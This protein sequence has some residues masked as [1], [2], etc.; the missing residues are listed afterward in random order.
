MPKHPFGPP[1]GRIETLTVEGKAL[2]G[3]LLGD[4]SR[5]QVSVYLPACYDQADRDYPLLVD[6]AGFTGSGPKHVAWRS[7]DESVPQRVDRLVAEDRM[8]PVIV[9]F[10]DCFTSLG[11]NQYVNS[12]AMGAWEDFLLDEMLPALESAL[13]VRRGPNHRAV[14]GKSSGGYGSL[15]QGLRHGERWAAIACHSGDMGFDFVYRRDLPVALTELA[16]FDGDAG[17]FVEHLWGAT[18]IRGA[19]MHV[20]MV[21]A[22]AATYDPDPEAPLGIRLPVDL[23]T[24]RLDEKRWARWLAHDPLT[25]IERPECRRSLS[26]LEGLF[27]DC[28]SKDQYFLQY[29][30]RAFV[31]RLNAF[32]IEHQY[33]E[34]DDTHSGIDYRM[35]RSLPFLYE[36]I[37]SRAAGSR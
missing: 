16:R 1:R 26:A 36:A 31:E 30:A 9:A 10:P 11:G 34:F 3:N 15:V 18:K 19:E 17:R 6:L 37:E 23:H 4:P 2:E 22:M 33:E 29:G 5:R 20:L 12:V 25:L 13:R 14:F 28:G 32:E 8:G 24:G 27:I 7:F 21:L 35:D